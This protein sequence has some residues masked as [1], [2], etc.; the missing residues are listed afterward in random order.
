MIVIEGTNLGFVASASVAVDSLI[1]VRMVKPL[2]S[3]V[4]FV[5]ENAIWT[6]FPAMICG[7]LVAQIFTI[8]CRV[9]EDLR[10]SSKVTHVMSINAV[11]RVV[12]ILAVWT[13]S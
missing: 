10:R 4:T 11:F 3:R 1:L 2:Y 9:L 6:H 7:L 13:P 8:L 12:R 5:A